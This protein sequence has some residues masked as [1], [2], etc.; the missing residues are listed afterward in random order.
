MKFV[1]QKATKGQVIIN[2][3]TNYPVPKNSKLYEAIQDETVDA[4]T[5]SRDRVWPMF[6][7]GAM[8][9]GSK[10][11]VIAKVGYSLHRQKNMY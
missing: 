3:L 5:T 1:P 7:D 6:I 2:F 8:R 9:M 11:K 4:N 10:G